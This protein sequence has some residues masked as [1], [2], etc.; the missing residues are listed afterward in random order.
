MALDEKTLDKIG[1]ASKRQLFEDLAIGVW[2]LEN[3]AHLR[4]KANEQMYVQAE[5]IVVEVR[6]HLIGSYG[7]KD[8][9]LPNY[10]G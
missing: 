7:M 1:N 3:T 9:E 10:S 6:N 4:C 5:E 8:A 2:F